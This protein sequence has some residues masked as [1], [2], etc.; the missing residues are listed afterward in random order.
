MRHKAELFAALALSMISGIFTT[1]ARAD[2]W[3]KRTTIAINQAIQIQDVVLQPGSYVL[4][5]VNLPSERNLVEV[6]NQAE[7]RVITTV[8]TVPV[9]RNEPAEDNEFK[10]YASA[11]AEAPAFYTWFYPVA[12]TGVASM[13]ATL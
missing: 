13:L 6:L 5:L 7:N 11:T 3:N 4:K 2:E 10:F 8:F 1:A 9:Q 12:S